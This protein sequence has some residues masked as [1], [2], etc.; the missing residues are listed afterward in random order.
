MTRSRLRQIFKPERSIRKPYRVYVNRS[1]QMDSIKSLGFDMDYT[2][3]IYKKEVIEHVAFDCTVEKLIRMKS[4]PDEIHKM[5]YDPISMIRGLVIDRKLG[6][7]LK[8]DQYGYVCKVH[9]GRRKLP[10]EERLRLYSK[11][12]IRLNN[13]RFHSVDTLFSLP[14]AYLYSE[15]VHFFDVKEGEAHHD[16]WKLWE[17]VRE[18]LDLSHRDNSIKAPIMAHPAEYVVK[19]A[20]LAQTLDRWRQGG[21]RLFVLTNSAWD[22][23]DALMTYLLHGALDEYPS[24]VDYFDRVI[25]DAGKPSFFSR[26]DGFEDLNGKV[27]DAKELATAKLM[28]KG[29]NRLLERIEGFRGEDVLFVGDH[30]YGDIL[31]SKQSSGWRTV[32]V[33]EELEGELESSLR[34]AALLDRMR[35][36]EARGNQLDFERSTA[37]RKMDKQVQDGGRR[38]DDPGVLDLLKEKRIQRYLEHLRIRLD[39]TDHSIRENDAGLDALKR[40]YDRQFNPRWGPL[41]KDGPEM[42]RFGEQ[43][44]RF[45]C[46]YTSKV[47][48]F[49]SYPPNK[50]FQSPIGLLPHD[51]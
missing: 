46:L 39:A 42:S 27:L 19:D 30:I 9:H 36:R 3:A 29:N 32:M 35:D 7:V 8:M 1:L 49:I 4:Y 2:L 14:E 15:L 23:T 51:L 40:E 47:S 28:R 11:S 10:S 38:R 50:Y 6:N 31:R 20:N 16:Y 34:G 5:V 24:W 26:S 45:A 25:V 37:Q 13:D 22:Y 43:V 48:N 21:K 17:D 33:V 18:C 12:R 44:Q 41:F